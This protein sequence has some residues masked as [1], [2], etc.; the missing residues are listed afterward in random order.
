[1]FKKELKAAWTCK[2][3]E[4]SR[5]F[6]AKRKKQPVVENWGRKG[7]SSDAGPTKYEYSGLS[8]TL[9]HNTQGRSQRSSKLRALVAAEACRSTCSWETCRRRRRRDDEQVP[10]AD[11]TG[12]RGRCRAFACVTSKRPLWMVFFQGIEGAEGR[13]RQRGRRGKRREEVKSDREDKG[14]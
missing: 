7:V 11:G 5:I 6:V 8:Q 14:E 2:G 3:G 4:L 13:E 1:M 10:Q 12:C 9:S